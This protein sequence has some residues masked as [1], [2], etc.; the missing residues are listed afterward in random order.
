MALC[1]F[2]LDVI[3][4][5]AGKPQDSIANWGAALGASLGPLKS[6]G[7]LRQEIKDG[8]MHYV[9]TDKGLAAINTEDK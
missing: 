8:G 6:S 9:V 7:Y 1:D 3:R 5:V 4:L 2:E